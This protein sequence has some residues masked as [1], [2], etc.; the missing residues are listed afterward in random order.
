MET[1][2]IDD[3]KAQL[4]RLQLQVRFFSVVLVVS[5]ALAMTSG[6]L[7]LA[8]T[9]DSSSSILRA[10]GLII[11]D[12]Q[13][14]ER[15][16]LG[17]PVPETPD[18]RRT[19]STTGIILLGENRAD[20]VAIGDPGPAPQVEGRV[21]ARMSPEAGITFDDPEGN[22]RGGFGYLDDG[23]VSLGLNYPNRDNDRSLLSRRGERGQ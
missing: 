5:F 1:N 18:R 10:R 6:I 8:S 14:H 16:L 19:D 17:A 22:E 4:K 3:L 21:V 13:G 12:A 2:S 23:T 11:V 20:R 15:I 9:K 7:R